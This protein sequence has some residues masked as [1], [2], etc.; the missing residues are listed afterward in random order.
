M[1]R[2]LALFQFV[3]WLYGCS[4]PGIPPASP[5]AEVA[6]TCVRAAPGDAVDGVHCSSGERPAWRSGSSP[7]R[8]DPACTGTLGT[9]PPRT[10]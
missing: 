2:L 4:V 6:L 1:A 3:L 5:V 7:H 8:G 9:C 10:R